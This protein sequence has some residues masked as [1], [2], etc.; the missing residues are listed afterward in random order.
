MGQGAGGSP[1]Q[2]NPLLYLSYPA[3]VQDGPGGGKGG[4]SFSQTLF[5]ISVI[6]QEFRPGRDGG[7]GGPRSASAKPSSLS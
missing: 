2:P 5:F 6:P 1:H 7:R 4:P 3:E